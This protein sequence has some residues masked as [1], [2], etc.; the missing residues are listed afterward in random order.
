MFTLFPRLSKK[1]T[2]LCYP[3]VQGTTHEYL[4][5]AAVACLPQPGKMNKNGEDAFFV[6]VKSTSI[7]V[8]DGV[9]GWA[10]LNVD[11]SA[12]S[13]KFCQEVQ[14]CYDMEGI[15]DPIAV[16]QRADEESVEVL[17]SST[18][19]LV[20]LKSKTLWGANVG[21][22]KFIVVRSGEVI[23]QSKEQQVEWNVPFQMGKKSTI[24]P[25]THGDRYQLDLEINDL[26]IMGSDGLFDNLF[27][28]EIVSLLD[29]VSL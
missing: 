28:T 4:L 18:A 29:K 14:K 17:G 26:I 13:N 11:P 22:S 27:I 12:Y 20:I 24:H 10:E 19:C 15:E 6:S 25:K 16:L 8:F 2:V 21:D 7:G 9:G 5:D 3:P 23:L 1:D